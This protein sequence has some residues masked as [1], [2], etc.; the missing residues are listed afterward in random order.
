[1][2]ACVKDADVQALVLWQASQ[3]AVVG[4]WVEGLPVA[5]VPLWQ[6]AQLPWAIPV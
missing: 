4:I 1:M 3:E 6:V 2:P 5:I